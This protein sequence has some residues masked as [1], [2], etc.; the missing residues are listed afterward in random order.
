MLHCGDDLNDQDTRISKA[1]LIWKMWLTRGTSIFHHF[2][3]IFIRRFL[4][5]QTGKLTFC[6][7]STLFSE[8]PRSIQAALSRL[9]AQE[10][11]H[12]PATFSPTFIGPENPETNRTIGSETY[13]P[14]LHINCLPYPD[15]QCSPPSQYLMQQEHPV[16]KS[17]QMAKGHQK[18]T[19]NK[20]QVKMTPPKN[21]YTNTASPS[22]TNIT[23]TQENDINSNIIKMIKFF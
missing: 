22:Y 4:L 15:N 19:I 2:S 9:L 6:N 1:I 14:R 20:S 5:D 11:L 23:K 17:P 7:A 18:N 12:Y 10:D 13:R 21:S 3:W 16:T 8:Y